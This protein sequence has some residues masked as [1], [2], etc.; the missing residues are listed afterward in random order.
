MHIWEKI[1]PLLNLAALTCWVALLWEWFQGGVKDVPSLWESCHHFNKHT[2]HPLFLVLS[3][4]A[5]G[6]SDLSR[7]L[8]QVDFFSLRSLFSLS[9]FISLSHPLPSPPFFSRCCCG[10]IK[11]AERGSAGESSGHQRVRAAGAAKGGWVTYQSWWVQA[12]CAL[13]S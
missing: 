5:D 12:L 6:M 11:A 2:T 9:L 3:S 13:P 4:L 8:H 10:K 1:K 7:F